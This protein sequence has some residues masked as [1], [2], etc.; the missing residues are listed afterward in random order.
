MFLIERV[1][2]ISF[3]KDEMHIVYKIEKTQSAAASQAE[4]GSHV[5]EDIPE[6][7]RSR[8]RKDNKMKKFGKWLKAIFSKCTYVAE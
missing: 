1:T 8:S 6:T 5:H 4:G 3:L 2:G 7:S